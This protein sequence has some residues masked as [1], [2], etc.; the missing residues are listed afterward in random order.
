M[1]VSF[2]MEACTKHEITPYSEL[3]G[4]HPREFVFDHS[5]HM[6]PPTPFAPWLAADDEPDEGS[7]ASGAASD[8][9]DEEGE[10]WV[11]VRT[12]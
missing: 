7:C 11:V 3:Y 4:L 6:V 12:L 1:K 5:F 8:S 2:D 9:E 10:D